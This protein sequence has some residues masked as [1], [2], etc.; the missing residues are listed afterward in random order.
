MNEMYKQ[1]EGNTRERNLSVIPQ[2]QLTPQNSGQWVPK[3][4]HGSCSRSEK[5]SNNHLI[6]DSCW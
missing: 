3:K 2:S 1:V 6:S 4:P 5:P